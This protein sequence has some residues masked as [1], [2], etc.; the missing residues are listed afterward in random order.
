MDST[1]TYRWHVS[2]IHLHPRTMNLYMSNIS[3]YFK[4]N[5]RMRSLY[6]LDVMLYSTWIMMIVYIRSERGKKEKSNTISFKILLARG[7]GR[8]WPPSLKAY[9]TCVWATSTWEREKLAK[10]LLS[11]FVGENTST[12]HPTIF[13]CSCI[14][15]PFC[16]E[17]MHM[18]QCSIGCNIF[19]TYSQNQ[20]K[21]IL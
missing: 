8:G 2:S 15:M 13:P 16:C 18:F 9:I 21:E 10:H 7:G 19:T 4:T 11:V 12:Y 1:Q 17:C 5:L 14:C 3:T 20:R 6:L